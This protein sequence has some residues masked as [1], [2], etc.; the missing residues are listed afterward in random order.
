M[1]RNKDYFPLILGIII[2]KKFTETEPSHN[3]MKG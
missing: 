2:K 3:E 1:R